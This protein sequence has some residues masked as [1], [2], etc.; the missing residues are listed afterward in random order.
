M[1]IGLVVRRWQVGTL[2][3]PADQN[4]QKKVSFNALKR[5]CF[6]LPSFLL[7]SMLADNFSASARVSLASSYRHKS[8]FCKGLLYPTYTH[9]HQSKAKESKGRRS[10]YHHQ[11]SHPAPCQFTPPTGID[12]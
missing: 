4:C 12:I 11:R 5:I 10:A 8:S 3:M 6:V 9:Q 1:S 2:R 7:F